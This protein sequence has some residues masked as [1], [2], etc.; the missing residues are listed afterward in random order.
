MLPKVGELERA[1]SLENA[2]IGVFQRRER[3]SLFNLNRQLLDAYIDMGDLDHA[4]TY[5][6]HDRGD[7][8]LHLSDRLAASSAR[9]AAKDPA[10]AELVRKQQDLKKQIGSLLTD[11]N[12]MLA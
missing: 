11:M 10:L 7:S 3:G 9:A 4:E 12:N 1:I 8:A 2:Q 6:R 5:L